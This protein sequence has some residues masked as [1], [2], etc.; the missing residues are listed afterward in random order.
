MVTENNST[1]YLIKISSA[2]HAL[3]SKKKKKKKRK[4]K[5]KKKKKR[6]KNV[7]VG[8]GVVGGR[9]TADFHTCACAP[10]NGRRVDVS[11]IHDGNR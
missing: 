10:E 6:E 4:K 7:R 1:D 5:K 11:S 3:P 8:M 9:R 2:I